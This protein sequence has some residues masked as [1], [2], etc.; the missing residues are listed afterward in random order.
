M[1]KQTIEN[2]LAELRASQEAGQAQLRD[3]EQKKRELEGTL[4]RISG[5]IQVL[6]E[7][8]EESGD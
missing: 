4:L 3:L 8:K 7:M 6:Q 1:N 2:K 5:A